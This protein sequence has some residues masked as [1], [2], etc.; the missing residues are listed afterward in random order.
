MIH[1][2]LQ[3]NHVP[4][5]IGQGRSSRNATPVKQVSATSKSQKTK[6]ILIVVLLLDLQETL[7]VTVPICAM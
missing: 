5:W 1:T 7:K 4:F 2:L 6:T 3:L